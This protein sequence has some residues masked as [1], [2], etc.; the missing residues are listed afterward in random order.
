VRVRSIEGMNQLADFSKEG[1]QEVKRQKESVD[2][3]IRPYCQ[4]L[5]QERLIL[6]QEYQKEIIRRDNYHLRYLFVRYST[7]GIFASSYLMSKRGS[8]RYSLRNAFL[9]YT[10]SSALVC[11]ESLNPFNKKP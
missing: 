9:F 10:L 4:S 8:L 11:P 1:W 3:L 6:M 5:R 2:S 7:F